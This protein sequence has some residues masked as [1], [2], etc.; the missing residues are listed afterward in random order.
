M[1]SHLDRAQMLMDVHRPKEA[2]RALLDYLADVPNSAQAHAM[3]AR[4][5]LELNQLRDAKAEIEQAIHLAP[6]DAYG[7]YIHSFVLRDL[8]RPKE[9]RKAIDEALQLSPDNPHYLAQSADLMC[10]AGW[11]EEAIREAESGLEID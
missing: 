7:H 2:A 8:K 9:A 11:Y 4:C 3:L 5:H 10:H 1:P 6:D